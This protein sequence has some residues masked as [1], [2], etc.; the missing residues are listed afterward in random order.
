MKH[1]SVIYITPVSDFIAGRSPRRGGV[2]RIFRGWGTNC[3]IRPLCPFPASIL[4]DF[5]ACSPEEAVGA[6]LR[7]RRI[8]ITDNRRL[9]TDDR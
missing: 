5:P 6:V 2:P 4:L 1:P 3:G 8:P 7:L 9:K